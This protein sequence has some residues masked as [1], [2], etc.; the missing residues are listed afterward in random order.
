M[1]MHPVCWHVTVSTEPLLQFGVDYMFVIPC[2]S[3]LS[4]H[5]VE[6]STFVA[7]VSQDWL[8]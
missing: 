3:V 1:P 6:Q 7:L 4:V 8:P 2:V 5:L